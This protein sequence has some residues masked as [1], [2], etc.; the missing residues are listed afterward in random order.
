[1]GMAHRIS[2]MSTFTTNRTLCHNCTSLPST[3]GQTKPIRPRTCNIISE[4]RENCKQILKKIGRLPGKSSSG[5]IKKQRQAEIADDSNAFAGDTEGVPQSNCRPW[6]EKA[7]F[8]GENRRSKSRRR[9]LS[10][11]GH[12]RQAG[13]EKEAGEL[14]ARRNLTFTFLDPN[15]IMT[16]IPGCRRLLFDLLPSAKSVFAFYG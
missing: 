3:I 11:M 5:E 15:I 14:E 7:G 6:K 8:S 2:E 4:D 16:I 1:M 12:T 10:V 9:R 13:S